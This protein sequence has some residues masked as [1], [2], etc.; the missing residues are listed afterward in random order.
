[1]REIILY[2]TTS[3]P[4]LFIYFKKNLIYK[5]KHKRFLEKNGIYINLKIHT[6]YK[7]ALKRLMYFYIF[8]LYNRL[9]W[10][11]RRECFTKYLK[12]IMVKT[13]TNETTHFGWRPFSMQLFRKKYSKFH[14]IAKLI[15]FQ[16]NYLCDGQF[17]KLII[18]CQKVTRAILWLI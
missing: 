1:M 6:A 7:W 17:H 5:T 4:I 9:R 16:L 8:H 12:N 15:F 10:W 11:M 3:S 13:L 2:F 18:F 14:I